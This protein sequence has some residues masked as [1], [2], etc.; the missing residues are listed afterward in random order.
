MYTVISGTNRSDSNTLRIAR[1]YQEIL[2]KRG[3]NAGLLS[4]EGL[5]VME[6]NPAFERVEQ[7]LLIPVPKFIFISPEYNG[8]IPG[9]L[10]ADRKSVV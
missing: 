4:L 7:E 1:I 8:S 3:I 6:R 2:L 10:K 9:V 5:N